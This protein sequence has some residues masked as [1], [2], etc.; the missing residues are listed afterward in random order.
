[1]YKPI[2]LFP[3]W[4]KKEGDKSER[5]MARE[6]ERQRGITIIITMTLLLLPSQETGP[7]ITFIEGNYFCKGAKLYREINEGA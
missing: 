6:R 4:T 5:E 7:Q 1:M 3:I 2:C